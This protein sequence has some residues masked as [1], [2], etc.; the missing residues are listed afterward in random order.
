MDE[1]WEVIKSVKTQTGIQIDKEVSNKG[2]V[3]MIAY[4]DGEQIAKYDFELGKGLFLSKGKIR[5]DI[6]QYEIN[7]IQCGGK[8]YEM[9]YFMKY[10]GHRHINGYQIHHLDFNHYNNDINNLVYC[11]AKQHGQYHKWHAYNQNNNAYQ[12]GI[13]LYG[14]TF[15]TNVE[16]HNKAK[17][18]RDYLESNYDKYSIEVSKKWYD[19]VR[20]EIENIAKPLIEKKRAELRMKREKEQKE[21]LERIKQER[22]DKINSGDYIE[23]DGKLILIHRPKWTAERRA[24][25]IKT[26]REQCYDNPIWRKNVSNGLKE[27]YRNKKEATNS[28][29]S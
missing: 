5:N 22:L 18:Y 14:D 26:R 13:D 7:I 28:N 2:H 12:H 19:S 4:Y 27:M 3:R 11:T 23:V 21:R 6:Q 15:I 29:L 24:K 1:I 9:V 16:L 10:T 20:N 8:L 25:T 17:E